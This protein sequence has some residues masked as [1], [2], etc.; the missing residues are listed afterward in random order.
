MEVHSRK[1][2]GLCP[3]CHMGLW[4]Q[5]RSAQSSLPTCWMGEMC[6]GRSLIFQGSAAAAIPCS[7]H[8]QSISLL[9]PSCCANREDGNFFITGVNS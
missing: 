1:N 7:P 3:L 6:P 8:V 9:L 4:N 2:V 5:L